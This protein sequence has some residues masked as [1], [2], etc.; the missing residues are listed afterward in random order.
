MRL[1]LCAALLAAALGGLPAAAAIADPLRPARVVTSFQAESRVGNAVETYA[2]SVPESFAQRWVTSKPFVGDVVERGGMRWIGRSESHP[3]IVERRTFAARPDG[4][5]FSRPLAES[6]DFALARA[7]A[8][9]Q[10]LRA[11]L[12]DGRAAWRTTIVLHE[13][14]C[15]ALARGTLE[16]WL[17]RETLLPLRTVERR[18][19]ARPIDTRVR[20]SRLA[21]V[22]ASAFRQPPL[23][24]NPDRVDYGFVRAAPAAAAPR[25]G[26][27]PRLPR[28][29]P[30]GFR[31]TVTGWAARS[32]L[33]GPEG[34]IPRRRALFG[35]VYRRGFER[36]DVTQRLAGGRD[37]ESDPFGIEC[38]FQFEERAAVG[39]KP[40]RYALGESITPHL[41]WRD[42]PLLHTV[43]G[44]FP[45][46]TL[47]A[48]AESLTP[49]R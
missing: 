34:S 14:K 17:D 42:G 20:Y 27:A 23:R 13:N 2:W 15:A 49:A 40:A 21:G 46:A 36:I 7:R 25:L 5:S 26:Y 6:A 35:A 37:W 39:G 32:N 47:V 41:Y 4:Y 18:A 44:P 28:E 19:R 43:S 1:G 24:S 29:L 10:R 31:L 12:I 45:K 22:P 8:G 33:T 30:A 38:G 11:D 9:T 48:I 16:L 3:G